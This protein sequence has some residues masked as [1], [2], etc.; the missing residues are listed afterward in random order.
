[1]SD[2]FTPRRLSTDENHRTLFQ[3][4]LNSFI[5]PNHYFDLFMQEIINSDRPTPKLA[6]LLRQLGESIPSNALQTQL[7]LQ[8]LAADLFGTDIWVELSEIGLG[9]LEYVH[10]DNLMVTYQRVRDSNSEKE[11]FDSIKENGLFEP[12]I[13]LRNGPQTPRCRIW[14]GT[15]RYMALR[16]LKCQMIPVYVY[17]VTARLN[18]PI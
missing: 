9:Q 6:S 13:V 18:R 7:T 3:R 14:D 11:M 4:V 12:L 2:K 17:P 5:A 10:A 1:M 15:L 8:E 16:L